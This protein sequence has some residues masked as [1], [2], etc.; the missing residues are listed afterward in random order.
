MAD[1]AEIKRTILKVAT[2]KAGLSSSNAWIPDPSEL[3]WGIQSVSDS[4]AGRDLKGKM[5]V[6]LRTR[7]RKLELKWSGIDFNATKEVLQAVNPETF[8]VEYYDALENKRVPRKFYVGDRTAMVN[9][10]V[11]GQR[12]NDV[13][14]NI[15]E[16]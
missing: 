3:Q 13:A 9:S 8:W 6:K 14:F 10:Y 1:G 15:I 16:V 2:T 7:K 11:A 4:D 5:H 12:R